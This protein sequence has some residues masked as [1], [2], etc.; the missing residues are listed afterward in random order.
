MQFVIRAYDGAN[1][2]EKRMSVRQRH[3]EN[4]NRLFHLGVE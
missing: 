3:L 2:L 4:A 1:S